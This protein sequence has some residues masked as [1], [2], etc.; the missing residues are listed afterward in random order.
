MPVKSGAKM[1]D[2]DE[3]GVQVRT[4]FSFMESEIL[5][6]FVYLRCGQ[7]CFGEDLWVETILVSVGYVVGA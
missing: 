7:S 6:C 2:T 5:L 4:F 3:K 1:P